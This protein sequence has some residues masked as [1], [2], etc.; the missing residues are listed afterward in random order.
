MRVLGL[1]QADRVPDRTT[2]WLCR[3]ALVKMGAMEAL[4]ARVAAELN[5]RG[6]FASGGQIIDASI[7]VSP[8]QRMIA[9]EKRQ[10]RDGEDPAPAAGQGTPDGHSTALDGQ[11]RPDHGEARPRA[12]AARAAASARPRGF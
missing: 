10:I 2:I 8:R 6:Y 3:E 7:V 5:A 9:E 12:S 1:S 11:A 4:F